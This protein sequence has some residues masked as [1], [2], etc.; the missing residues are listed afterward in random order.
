MS[1]LCGRKLIKVQMSP[2]TFC[3]PRHSV[4]RNIDSAGRGQ[5]IKLNFSKQWEVVV[6]GVW[7]QTTYLGFKTQSKHSQNKAAFLLPGQEVSLS[8]F[9]LTFSLFGFSTIMINAEKKIVESGIKKRGKAMN[10]V[11]TVK[12]T[13]TLFKSLEAQKEQRQEVW[14]GTR[15]KERNKQKRLGLKIKPKDFIMQKVDGTVENTRQKKE[16]DKNTNFSSER[17]TQVQ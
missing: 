5:I 9:H 11:Q 12:V 8:L 15:L 4:R 16:E 7:V 1:P 13:D 14:L 3:P 10:Q 6:P 2:I 17:V